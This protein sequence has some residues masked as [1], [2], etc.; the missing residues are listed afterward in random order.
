M[1]WLSALVSSTVRMRY[2]ILKQLSHESVLE[3]KRRFQTALDA[4]KTVGL[5]EIPAPSQ[6][7]RFIIKLDDDRFG[8]FKADLS[9]WAKNGIK[10]Y[11]KTLEAAYESASTHK[12]P[13]FSSPV[14][15]SGTAYVVESIRK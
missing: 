2:E 9:N 8:K 13:G 6:A 1:S 12:D 11:P 10:E 14:T 7:A 15:H 4:M 5:P 3:Y